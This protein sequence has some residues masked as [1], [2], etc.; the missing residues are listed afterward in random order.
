LLAHVGACRQRRSAEALVVL[1][2]VG[3][4]PGHDPAAQLVV[5]HVEGL[6]L[7][8]I[9][10]LLRDAPADA[11]VAQVQQAQ[12]LLRQLRAGEAETES[13][14]RQVQLLH[15]LFPPEQR[16]RR[17]AGDRVPRQV[18]VREADGAELGRH[19]AG[20][21]V[22]RQPQVGG[23]AFFVRRYVAEEQ[24][25]DG[26]GEAVAAEVDAGEAGDVGERRRDGAGEGVVRQVQ[27]DE[28]GEPGQ[29]RR[30]GPRHAGVGDGEQ[31]EVTELGERLRDA[32]GEARE[33]VQDEPL[34]MGEVGDGVGEAAGEV[35][36]MEHGQAHHAAGDVVAVHVVPVAAPRVR[37]PRLKW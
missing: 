22:V 12:L 16:R 36:V 35:G 28:R 15:R 21:A 5:A 27:R 11:V 31:G 19:A 30:H 7:R 6:Q 9:R 3:V 33:V 18:D 14:P 20:E 8:Q 17:V 2:A 13:V 1:E 25:R 29:E 4:E 23:M 24:R 34:E 26:A 32:A 10:H 37:A